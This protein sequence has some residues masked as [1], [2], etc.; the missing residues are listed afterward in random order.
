MQEKLLFVL[1]MATM[2]V[3]YKG[4]LELSSALLFSIS[5]LTQNEI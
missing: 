3:F 5:Y 1:K 2:P 4:V